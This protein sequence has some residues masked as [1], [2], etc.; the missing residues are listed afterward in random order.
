M[1][2]ARPPHHRCPRPHRLADAPAPAAATASRPPAS[3]PEQSIPTVRSPCPAPVP[4]GH[5]GDGVSSTADRTATTRAVCAAGRMRT[6]SR[7]LPQGA[8]NLRGD[9]LRRPGPRTSWNPGI[10]DTYRAPRRRLT[11]RLERSRTPS[12][13]TRLHQCGEFIP[14]GGF[15]CGVFAGKRELGPWRSRSRPMAVSPRP[16]PRRPQGPGDGPGRR[17]WRCAP[18]I[19]W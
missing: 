5:T 3:R 12:Q 2:A 10:A 13:P 18:G 14:Y 8:R 9:I 6:L 4:T 16:L 15:W 11:A 17:Y 7:T 19:S 1:I